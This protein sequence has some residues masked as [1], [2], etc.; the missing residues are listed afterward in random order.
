MD[1]RYEVRH[2]ALQQSIKPVDFDEKSER[3]PIPASCCH[4]LS[5]RW[6]GPTMRFRAALMA[7]CALPQTAIGATQECKTIADP[8][9]RL[10][11]YDKIN[12]PIATNP[13]PLPKPTHA[14]PTTRPDGS[15]YMGA[16]DEEDAV[17][18]AQ[19]RSICRG[20]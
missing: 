5:K 3:R 20:C 16:Q 11:C 2:F 7:I 10:T 4:D 19:M 17:L 18:K 8:A 9:L 1:R 14:I 15:G 12:S 6:R 13:I